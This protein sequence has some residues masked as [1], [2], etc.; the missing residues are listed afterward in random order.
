[1]DKLLLP[2]ALGGALLLSPL[3][4]AAL[5]AVDLDAN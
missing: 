5:I 2:S 4:Q 1:M 3:A